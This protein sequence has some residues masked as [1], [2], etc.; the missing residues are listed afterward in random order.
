MK[1]TAISIFSMGF[2]RKNN[3]HVF[4]HK[5]VIKPPRWACFTPFAPLTPQPATAHPGDSKTAKTLGRV[6]ASVSAIGSVGLNAN[7]CPLAEELTK[8][9]VPKKHQQQHALS[10]ATIIQCNI[11]ATFRNIGTTALQWFYST[12]VVHLRLPRNNDDIS[13]HYHW[14]S[15]CYCC[16]C[17]CCCCC[18]WLLLLLLL[19]LLG[20]P[21][22]LLA[23]LLR[24][25]RLQLLAVIPCS[26]NQNAHN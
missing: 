22:L 4:P 25:L 23:C 20:L 15:S 16:C 9:R 5:I 12:T 21:L 10:T 24:L 11:K 17:C 8:Y 26:V 6:R 18:C 7:S 3:F 19:L 13:D 14:N 1:K 2:G